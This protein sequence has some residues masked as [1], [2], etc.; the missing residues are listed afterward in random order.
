MF[1]NFED[2]FY[3][4]K[5]R[6]LSSS[7]LRKLVFYNNSDALT[8]TTR[9]IPSIEEA[10]TNIYVKPIIFVTENSEEFGISSFISIGLVEAMIMDNAIT[11]SI[12]V[13]VACDRQVWELEDN[14]VRPLAIL[15][16]IGDSLDG[17]KISSAGRLVIRVV[18]EVYFN[19]ELVGYTTL[20]DIV[21]E[22][23]SVVNEF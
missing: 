11:G 6:L 22:K 1:R 8:N 13:S 17:F 12:K 3:Q 18:S 19:N 2:I 16:I 10:S 21:E 7:D 5:N 20:F 23:G 9:A 15:S 14:R 4:I